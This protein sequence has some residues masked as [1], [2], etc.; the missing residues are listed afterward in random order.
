MIKNTRSTSNPNIHTKNMFRYID[1]TNLKH[2]IFIN[3]G[4]IVAAMW[5]RG[6]Q[7]LAGEHACRIVTVLSH[8]LQAAG[9]GNGMV[10]GGAPHHCTYVS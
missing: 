1:F 9:I 8:D 4:S 5:W 3:G 2:L 7:Q 6:V 10:G